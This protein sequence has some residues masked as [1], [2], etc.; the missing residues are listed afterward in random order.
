MGYIIYIYIHGRRPRKI[1]LLKDVHLK[2]QLK[3]AREHVDND[4]M[5]WRQILWLDETKIEFFR[6]EKCE[7]CMERKK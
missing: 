3:F 7:V 1:L 6:P 5:Y 4:K 2:V